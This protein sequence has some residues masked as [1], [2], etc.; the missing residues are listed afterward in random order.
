M[1]E[2][3]Q[4]RA[5]VGLPFA[6]DLIVSKGEGHS[7]FSNR[8]IG[9][10][11]DA[12]A[13]EA[14]CSGVAIAHDEADWLEK[15]VEKIDNGFDYGFMTLTTN[16]MAERETEKAVK[17]EGT[18]RVGRQ[19]HQQVSTVAPTN[20][21]K[22]LADHYVDSERIPLPVLNEN[23]EGAVSSAGFMAGAESIQGEDK[24]PKRDPFNFVCA[25][26]FTGKCDAPSAPPSTKGGF[27]NAMKS[28]I[29]KI[30]V[31]Q[32]GMQ[33]YQRE[34]NSRKYYT[35]STRFL[36]D[37]NTAIIVTLS[38]LDQIIRYIKRI[39]EEVEVAQHEN[40]VMEKELLTVFHQ[41]QSW[42]ARARAILIHSH[43]FY[44]INFVLADEKSQ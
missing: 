4:R 8:E 6:P 13:L 15:Q 7:T 32:S 26:G 20:I 43:V 29:S 24:A 23:K 40:S 2:A 5:S 28:E 39:Q 17:V 41:A 10:Q 44:K 37:Q 38:Q 33:A 30:G 34:I 12:V 21:S 27:L 16:E 19:V 36:V 3:E 1:N 14:R 22:Y 9:N 18:I 31:L 25:F 35:F 11:W 42:V